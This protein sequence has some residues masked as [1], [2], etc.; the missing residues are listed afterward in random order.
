MHQLHDHLFKLVMRNKSEARRFL[1][2]FIN[3]EV[4]QAL[5]LDSLTLSPDTI[6]DKKKLLCTH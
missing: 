1:Q 4:V 3:P 6:I 2:H 5:N